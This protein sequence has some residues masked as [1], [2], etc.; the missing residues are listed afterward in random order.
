MRP[1]KLKSDYRVCDDWTKILWKKTT[2]FSTGI[3]PS[4]KMFPMVYAL[5]V[6]GPKSRVH[7]SNPL[8]FIVANCTVIDWNT[9]LIAP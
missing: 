5:H 3:V 8:Y 7:G 2:D 6:P 9:H 4:S 1:T